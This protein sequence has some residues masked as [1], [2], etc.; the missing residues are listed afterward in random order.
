MIIR[1]HIKSISITTRW[2]LWIYSCIKLRPSCSA[3]EPHNSSV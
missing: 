1:Y 3:I 2:E